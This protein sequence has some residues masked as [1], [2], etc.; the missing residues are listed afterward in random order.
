MKKEM[1]ILPKNIM[2]LFEEL[3]QECFTAIKYIQ[4]LKVK[5][6]TSSQKED[7]IGELSAAI[8]HLKIQAS[9]LDRELEDTETFK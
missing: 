2:V 6:L 8:T 7:I 4:A 5:E 3:E 9:E 1:Y